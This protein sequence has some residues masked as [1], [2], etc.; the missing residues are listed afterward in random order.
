M[1]VIRAIGNKIGIPAPYMKVTKVIII[2]REYLK[3][4]GNGGPE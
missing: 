4:M 2:I 1:K 3:W